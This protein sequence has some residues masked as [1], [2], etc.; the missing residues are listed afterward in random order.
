MTSRWCGIHLG[1]AHNPEVDRL[2]EE[3]P[4][5]AE[6]GL[7]VLVPEVNYQFAYRS[8]PELQ[9]DGPITRDRA[10][11]LA[12]ACREH[13]IRLIPQFQ[14]LGH[15][16]WAK[17][18][19]P[20]LIQYPEFDETP[21]Q[22]PNNEGIY[23]RSWCPQHPDV[24]P[25]I[26]NLFDELLEAFEADALHVGMDEVFLIGS[27]Y[28]P[29]CAGEDPAQLFAMAVNDYYG[30]LSERHVEM[31]M[32]G[33]R[34]LD[35]TT[36]GYGKWEAAENGTAP[37]ID[38][39]PRDIVICDWHY[40][41]REDYPSIPIFLAKGFPTW[42]AGWKDVE[43]TKALLTAA[44]DHADNP[45]MLGYLCT[46]WGQVR[47]GELAAWPPITTALTALAEGNQP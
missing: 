30:Y 21:G 8:H 5:L 46:T 10:Q 37:A 38:M 34:L 45:Q 28:C 39:I 26:F 23:C 40:E 6:M 14:C 27:E 18:T 22:Y 47:P 31:L 1:L 24:N 32:W 33:D 29:R 2:V 13:D 15:Q 20:L 17:R 19:F 36:T 7:N 41:V 12:R 25:I 35:A 42:P 4:T 3:I 16:S 9:G 43:A 44:L 11:R